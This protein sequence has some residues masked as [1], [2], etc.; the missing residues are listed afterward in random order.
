MR[1]VACV[2]HYLGDGQG[3]CRGKRIYVVGALVELD[4][5][6]C[7]DMQASLRVELYNDILS[8]PPE[9]P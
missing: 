6:P 2:C 3:W 4:G 1:F 5:Q 7:N 8:L 9:Y